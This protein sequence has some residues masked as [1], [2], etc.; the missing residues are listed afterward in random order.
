MKTLSLAIFLT[1]FFLTLTTPAL[2]QTATAPASGD[3]S[4]GNPYQIATW[5]NLYWVSQNSDSWDKNF[6]QTANI[7]FTDA[8]PAITTWNGNT[9][10]TPIG[11]TTTRFT[12]TYDGGGHTIS[13]LFIDRPAGDYQGLFG[14]TG[15]D[16]EIKNLGV[17]GVDIT[18]GDWVGGLV[19]VNAYA[20]TG[21]T[22]TNSYATGEVS[23]TSQVGGLVGRNN[24]TVEDSYATVTVSGTSTVGGLVGLNDGTVTNSYATGAVTGT[25]QV[26]GLVGYNWIGHKAP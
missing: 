13:G 18:A 4:P 5:Q 8:V 16:A 22:V 23:G 10:W 19:G 7:D 26:G 9:G 3:G 25:T 14:V 6:I 2:A 15:W 1:I 21:G 20:G 17:I 11:N 24:D 12:G